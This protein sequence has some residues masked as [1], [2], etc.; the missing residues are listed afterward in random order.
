MTDPKVEREIERVRE[1]KRKGDRKSVRV[2]EGG[3]RKKDI[4]RRGIEWD[5][6][7]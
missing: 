6:L 4:Y 5:S 1:N 2:R 3:K 7:L